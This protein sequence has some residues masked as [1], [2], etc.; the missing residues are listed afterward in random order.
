MLMTFESGSLEETVRFGRVL[1]DCLK[2]GDVVAL[3]GNLGAGKTHL[4]QAIAEGLGV[5]AEDVHS[6]TFVLIQEYDARL[7]IC[8]IDA[9]RLNDIDEFLELG[10]D[11]LVGGDCVA[12]IEWADRVAEVLPRDRLTVELTATGENARRLDISGSGARSNA[13]VEALTSRLDRSC[14]TTESRRHGEE[15]TTKKTKDTK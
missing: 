8:H 11:E 9:Y 2:A 4:V 12:L 15:G 3:I 6:P 7:P 1:A 5:S 13:I 14:F 10:A